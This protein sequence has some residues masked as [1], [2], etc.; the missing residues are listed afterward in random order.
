MNE[1]SVDKFLLANKVEIADN[2]FSDR[3]MQS[4]PARADWQQHLCH[5]WNCV[6]IIA[7]VLFCWQTD[8][9]GKILVDIEV[10]LHNMPLNLFDVQWWYGFA[11]VMVGLFGL[12]FLGGKKIVTE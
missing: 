6:F 2:G 12:V 7:L 4:L 9:F 1:N 10:Y 5:I 11:T 8:I 3:V